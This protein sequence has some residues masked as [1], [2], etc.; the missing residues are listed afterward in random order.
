MGKREVSRTA[1]VR[2]PLITLDDLRWLV[3]EFVGADG[4]SRVEVYGRRGADA[5]DVDQ[6]RIM[7]VAAPKRVGPG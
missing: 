6:E 1:E 7:V 4:R 3:E 2:G 5:A